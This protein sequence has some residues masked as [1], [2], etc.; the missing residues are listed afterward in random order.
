MVRLLLALAAGNDLRIATHDIAAAYLNAELDAD[1]VYYLEPPEILNLPNH[2]VLQLHRALYGLRV[3]AKKWYEKLSSTLRVIG[4]IAIGHDEILFLYRSPSFH[5]AA[6][7]YVD[8]I[9]LWYSNQQAQDFF[10]DNLSKFFEFSHNEDLGFF[11]GA[12]LHQDI[13]RGFITMSQ[14]HFLASIAKRFEVPQKRTTTILPE[15]YIK[16]FSEED[17]IVTDRRQHKLYQSAIGSLLYLQACSRPDISFA[18]SLLSRRSRA[19]RIKDCFALNHLM[20]FCYTTKSIH[21]RWDRRGTPHGKQFL[22][23]SLLAA[24]DASWG[25][26]KS[27]RKSQTG[28]LLLLNGS[29][30][31]YSSKLQKSVSLSSTES[32]LQ[33]CSNAVQL[34]IVFRQLLKELGFAQPTPTPLLLDNEASVRV[35]INRQAVS[36]L[37]HIDIKCSF[38]RDE[39]AKQTYIPVSVT[40][41]D[42]LADFLTKLLP[43]AR[44][45]QHSKLLFGYSFPDF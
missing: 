32:E 28:L 20:Q 33:A 45:R 6:T 35:L 40:S 16:L 5:I 21:L 23:N 4:F 42:Q 9:I 25:E 38:L 8:D 34:I 36:R 30:V 7:I 1:Q 2:Q 18:V 19:P 27:T 41:Q 3:S 12:E 44:L 43:L 17:T 39:I 11:L 29:L 13:E 10:V 24:S 14:E 22:H 37:K 26:C 31:S 15:S